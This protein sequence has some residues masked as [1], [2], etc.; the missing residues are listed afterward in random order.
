MSQSNKIRFHKGDIVYWCNQV[1]HNYSVKWGMVDEEYS[2]AILIDYLKPKEHRLVNGIHI[3]E[4]ESQKRYKKLPK[5]WSYDT[6]LYNIESFDPYEEIENLLKKDSIS[7]NREDVRIDNPVNIKLGYKYG[8]LVKANTIFN[9][10]IEADITKEGYKIVKKYPPYF[11]EI[12]H[13]SIRPDRLYVAYNDAQKEV[14]KHVAE[15]N[16]QANLSE[17][18]WSVE[19]IEHTIGRYGFLYNTPKE[20]QGKYLKWITDMDNVEDIEVRIFGGN[21]Q[22]KYWKNKRW[23]NI[24]L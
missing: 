1:G 10:V 20:T 11:Q 6:K 24:E 12:T 22:W 14:D 17:Y 21:I 9:G 13:T 15:F 3:D 16:R 19:Q 23:M 4:F 2:D 7:F 18:E 5:D 8:F